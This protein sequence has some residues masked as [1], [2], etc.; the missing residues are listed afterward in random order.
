MDIDYSRG[1]IRSDVIGT[2][3]ES[4]PLFRCPTCGVVGEIDEDQYRGRVSI[5]CPECTY[6]ETMDWSQ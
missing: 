2:N 6:H 1:F 3:A 4:F 5:E